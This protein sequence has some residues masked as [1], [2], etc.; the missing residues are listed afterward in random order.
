MATAT[1]NTTALDRETSG[2]WDAIARAFTNYARARSRTDRIEA[3]QKLSDA[4]LA[5]LGI[6]RDE[7]P[8]YVFRD[9]FYI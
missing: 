1:T 5:K 2:I 9:H 4:Q 8:V 3:L 7:I 6:T